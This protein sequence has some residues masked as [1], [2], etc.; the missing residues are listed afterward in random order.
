MIYYQIYVLYLGQSAKTLDKSL[1]MVLY[2]AMYAR[3]ASRELALLLL[4]QHDR[5]GNLDALFADDTLSAPI[6]AETLQPA[7]LS[8]VRVLTT[9]AMDVFTDMG[10]T[11]TA[12]H[13]TLTD[14]EIV[15]MDNSTSA[16]D[17]RLSATRLPNTETF[18]TQL[19]TLAHGINKLAEAARLPELLALAHDASVCAYAAKLLSPIQQH[20]TD[21]DEHINANSD[22]WRLERMT[23]LNRCVLR[24]AV[25]E[26]RYVEAVDASVVIDE[27]V[28]LSKTYGDPDNYKLVNGILG[29]I[30][31]TPT[32]H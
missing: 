19:D 5:Q 3:H 16:A 1:F 9:E 28:E 31:A 18:K 11:I 30:A 32:A 13:Q 4:F 2:G 20:L 27:A 12:A 25:A 29:G 14:T 8:L 24:L 26:M 17:A 21:I 15:A 22:D 23:K 10:H 7:V 6:T